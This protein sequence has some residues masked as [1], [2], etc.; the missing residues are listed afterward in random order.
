MARSGKGRE[1]PGWKAAPIAPLAKSRKQAKAPPADP[2][3]TDDLPGTCPYDRAVAA[4]RLTYAEAKT[5]DELHTRQ[6][7]AKIELEAA[8][9]ALEA[10]RVDLAKERGNLVSREEYIARQSAMVS[11]FMDLLKL[12]T[13]DIATRLPSTVREAAVDE[14][15]NRCQA[16]LTALAQAVIDKEPQE[17][18][19]QRMFDA[20]RG[21]A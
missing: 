9:L 5:R 20:F 11:V 4:G 16:A 8:T 10:K 6:E 13:T 14:V 3:P 19:A 18:A 1:H 7:L 21:V 2:P 17:I 12:A 15:G